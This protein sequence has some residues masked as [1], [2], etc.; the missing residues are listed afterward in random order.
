MYVFIDD[1]GDPGFK[2][3]KGSSR[4]FVI[5]CCVFET[6]SHAEEVTFAIREIRRSLGFSLDGEFKFSHSQ[7]QVH[8][9]FFLQINPAQFFVRVVVIDKH[10]VDRQELLL[11]QRSLEQWAI[12]R[13]L[14]HPSIRLHDARVFIDGK[15]GAKYRNMSQNLVRL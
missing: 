6:Q 10:H 1:S 3:D 12:A 7:E 15:Q 4:F 13:A 8:R 9:H 14:S 2:F 11:G 5:A